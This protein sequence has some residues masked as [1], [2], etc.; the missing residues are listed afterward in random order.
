[1]KKIYSKVL[2]LLL[3]AIMVLSI[4]PLNPLGEL[5]S[6]MASA[7]EFTDGFYTY[8]VDNENKATIVKV[9]T[10]ISGEQE[11]PSILGGYT[12]TSIADL[13]FRGCSSLTKLLIPISVTEIGNNSFS[14][15]TSLEN[16][17]VVFGNS[18]FAVINGVL[19][20]KAKTKLIKCPAGREE[21][22]YTVP[23][24]VTEL[25][26]Y[27][28]AGYSKLETIVFSDNLKKIGEFAFSVCTNLVNPPIPYGVNTI[29]TFAFYSCGKISSITIPSTVISIGGSAFEGTKL[30]TTTSNWED[31]KALYISNCL[32]EVKKAAG[33]SYDVKNGTRLIAD[34]AFSECADLKEITIPNSVMSIGNNIFVACGKLENISIADDNPNYSSADGVMFDKNKH[35]IYY[36]PKGNTRKNYDIPNSVTYI[37]SLAFEDSSLIEKITVPN[38]VTEIGNWAFAAC[39]AL[40]NI[41]VA[42]DNPNFSSSDG[43][44]FDKDQTR[45][46]QCPAGKPG[47]KYEIPNTVTEIG[48][49]AFTYCVSL[50]EVTLPDSLTDIGEN[51][52]YF[53]ELLEKIA[54][55]EGVTD[56]TDQTFY[57]CY[58]LA[59]IS[60]P[61]SV[62]AIGNYAFALCGALANVYYAGSGTDWEEISVCEGNGDL[63]EATFHFNHPGLGEDPDIPEEDDYAN[64]KLPATTAK[65]AR[66][67]NN[68]TVKITATGIPATGFLV[69]DG[70]R[71]KPDATGTATFETQFQATAGRSFKVHIEENDGTV[72]VAEKE[73][74]V[75]VN[76]GFFAKLSAFFSDF[77]FNGFKWKEATVEF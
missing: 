44:L 12:V 2:S 13:A 56:I 18:S 27:A 1:M 37:D 35:K 6:P 32:I 21:T 50:T 52:F 29:G 64:A 57:G 25:G 68:V 75:E 24:T 9:D 11:L 3:V 53:C 45:L 70:N 77:L 36:Y 34:K 15:C 4:A 16:F 66:Y 8:T 19:F 72:K 5:F 40:T 26:N 33:S 14:G 76:T 55:P 74:K 69:V 41:D 54:I 62:K 30:Y 61:N 39:P 49:L 7:T 67:K 43:V 22:S 58:S 65:T 31:G 20:N 59:K 28:F 63:T 51:A 71:I 47:P 46:I 42:N 60:F 48:I 73:Y 10:S 23:S 38:T 17:G